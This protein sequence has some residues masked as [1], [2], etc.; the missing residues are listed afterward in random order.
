MV[1][2]RRNRNLRLSEFGINDILLPQDLLGGQSTISLQSRGE[3]D[4]FHFAGS[5]GWRVWEA[6]T[7]KERQKLRLASESAILFERK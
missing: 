5:T 4:S 6:L 7:E 3:F 2:K 1:Q